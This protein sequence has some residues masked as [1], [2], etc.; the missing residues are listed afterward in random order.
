MV[1]YGIMW[2]TVYD[3]NVKISV[4]YIIQYTFQ[5]SL[6]ARIETFAVTDLQ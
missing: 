1:V 2:C 3:S 6:S 5:A 4:V